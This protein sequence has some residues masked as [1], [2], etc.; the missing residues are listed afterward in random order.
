MLQDSFVIHTS[1]HTVSTA[2]GGGGGQFGVQCLAQGH[3][4]THNGEAWDR[5]TDLVINARP[6]LPPQS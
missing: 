3:F 5:T 4:G 2:V 1:S 6:A